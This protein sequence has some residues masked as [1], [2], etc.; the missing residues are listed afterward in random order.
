MTRSSVQVYM[1]CDREYVAPAA[2]TIASIERTTHSIVSY[3]VLSHGMPE[4]AKKALQRLADVEIV[5]VGDS[6]EHLGVK[7]KARIASPAY[8]RLLIP[9]IA[10]G[11]RCVY[12]DVDVVFSDD[13]AKANDTDL[14]GMMVGAVRDVQGYSCYLSNPLVR[15]YWHDVVKADPETYFCS[16]FL[17]MDLRALRLADLPFVDTVRSYPWAFH[18]MD[19]LNHLLSGSV[20]LMD[21]RWVV[22]P[23]EMSKVEYL[24]EA[25]QTEWEAAQRN[26]AV[27]H[28]AGDAKPWNDPLMW[29]AGRWWEV[30][31]SLPE[32][33]YEES[34][35]L[36]ARSSA[37]QAWSTY[38]AQIASLQ[39]AVERL[40]G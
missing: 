10:K 22:M 37:K 31:R 13:I 15:D 30:A 7:S 2:V 34:L 23:P 3:H 27:Y 28:Y 18:D 17:V 6:L 16:G 14:K 38:N 12:T 24:S 5:E 26:P 9:Q 20:R 40:V 1:A 4:E 8:Y 33:L 21:S 11:D 32:P 29:E 39:T 36:L 19:V 35:A 25:E